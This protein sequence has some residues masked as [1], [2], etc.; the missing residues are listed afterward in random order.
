LDL[1]L[2]KPVFRSL[3]NAQPQFL[4]SR[5]QSTSLD[6]KEL[7]RAVLTGKASSASNDLSAND[8]QASFWRGY[9]E[10]R[11]AKGLSMPSLASMSSSSSFSG[12]QGFQATHFKLL[13][14]SVVVSTSG[15]VDT[16]ASASV[17][18][19]LSDCP[20]W[21]NKYYT[22]VTLD[23]PSE[24]MAN[25]CAALKGA[26]DFVVASP[27]TVEGLT[28]C[29]MKF[30]INLYQFTAG[31]AQMFGVRGLDSAAEYVLVE[32]CREQ[33]CAFGFCHFYRTVS[34]AYNSIPVCPSGKCTRQGGLQEPP[35]VPVMPASPSTT[36]KDEEKDQDQDQVHA[37]CLSS[38]LD[39]AESEFVGD[40][41]KE[42]LDTM[43]R[44]KDELL[45]SQLLARE[46]LLERATNVVLALLKPNVDAST[47]VRLSAST[48][49]LNMCPWKHSPEAQAVEKLSNSLPSLVS[50]ASRA[51]EACAS[52]DNH[53]LLASRRCRE[54]LEHVSKQ[55]QLVM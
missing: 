2:D 36:H 5:H 35:A 15:A 31:N 4:A 42:A 3:T 47:D 41:A 38:L 21:F 9:E 27:G 54:Q 50:A 52:G 43:N 16:D 25:I 37:K 39:M 10:P 55:M 22:S 1:S 30:S 34:E 32:C 23:S 17:Y 49:L 48:L 14:P 40:V 26:A 7:T 44:L 28:R 19:G 8:A 53:E 51:E 33:G 24:I 45:L 6:H 29:G 46:E 20:V 18:S 11:A 13:N 12:E